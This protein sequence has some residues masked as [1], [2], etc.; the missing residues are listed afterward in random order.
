[1]FDCLAASLNV[2][3]KCFPMFDQVQTFS[4][5]IL[6]ITNKSFQDRFGTLSHKAC[7]SRKKQPIK[8]IVSCMDVACHVIISAVICTK[9]SVGSLAHFV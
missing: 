4:C 1:M 8:S 2:A 6:Q 3:F 9:C 5:N 7:K